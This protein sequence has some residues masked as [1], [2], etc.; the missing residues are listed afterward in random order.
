[1]R[2]N[3]LFRSIKPALPGFDAETG[4]NLMQ[5]VALDVHD[6][7]E[8]GQKRRAYHHNAKV[9]P[10]HLPQRL[11]RL[12]DHANLSLK[13]SGRAPKAPARDVAIA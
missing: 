12:Y 7:R 11:E 10:Q 9:A 2:Q 8:D 1:M 13:T 3:R 4:L 6:H 5:V